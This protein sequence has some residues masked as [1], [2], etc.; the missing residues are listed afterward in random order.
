MLSL[1]DNAGIEHAAMHYHANFCLRRQV[2]NNGE[3]MSGCCELTSALLCVHVVR[4]T[5]IT[6]HRALKYL[7]IMH[8]YNARL[9]RWYH[10]TIRLPMVY[11]EAVQSMKKQM[12]SPDWKTLDQYL[13]ILAKGMEDSHWWILIFEHLTIYGIV[14]YW[15]TTS[16][17][18]IRPQPVP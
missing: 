7:N 12:D 6:D 13:N 3:N 15:T 2:H 8:N 16:S 4:F 1:S 18:R 9:T 17:L 5:V 11:I 14:N 10:P